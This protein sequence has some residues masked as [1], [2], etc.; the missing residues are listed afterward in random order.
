MPVRSLA[1]RVKP[2]RPVAGTGK[3]AVLKTSCCCQSREYIGSDRVTPIDKPT[4]MTPTRAH[5]AWRRASPNWRALLRK[6]CTEAEQAVGLAALLPKQPAGVSSKTCFVR[7]RVKGLLHFREQE[8]RAD[9]LN[10]GNNGNKTA[11]PRIVRANLAECHKHSDTVACAPLLIE[12]AVRRAR[13]A[14]RATASLFLFDNNWQR[15]T[16]RFVFPNSVL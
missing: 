2:V 7:V 4:S 12:P 5:L 6:H 14:R 15:T 9:S 13:R 3:E 16:I 10:G 11:G 8:A 1:S